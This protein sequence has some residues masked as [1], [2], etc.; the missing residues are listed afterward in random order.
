MKWIVLVSNIS[1]VSSMD[2]M[3]RRN[4]IVS[5]IFEACRIFTVSAVV[6]ILP[7]RFSAARH[8]CSTHRRS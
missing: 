5:R 6:H 4:V 1:R 8:S 3:S 2:R 7:L